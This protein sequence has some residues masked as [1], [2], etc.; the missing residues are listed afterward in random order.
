MTKIRLID[1]DLSERVETE[2]IQF[3]DDFPGLFVRGDDCLTLFFALHKFLLLISKNKVD[4]IEYGYLVKSLVDIIDEDVICWT[5]K[6][7]TSQIM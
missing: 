2:A 5:E 3:G 1:I 7:E 6:R 4:D